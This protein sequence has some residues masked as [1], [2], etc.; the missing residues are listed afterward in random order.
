MIASFT[1]IIDF[2]TLMGKTS[3]LALHTPDVKT[4]KKMMPGLFQTFRK[5][6]YLGASVRITPQAGALPLDPLGVSANPSDAQ[7]DPRDVF[8]PILFR[9]CHGEDLGGIMNNW[10]YANANNDFSGIGFDFNQIG[11][12]GSSGLISADDILTPYYY[13]CLVDKHWKKVDPNRGFSKGNFRPLVYQ[14]AS[15]R[16]LNPVSMDS[17]EVFG[18][19]QDYGTSMGESGV[20]SVTG[21]PEASISNDD[22][23]VKYRNNI[24]FLTPRLTT[25]GWM[26]TRQSL[27]SITTPA[28]QSV[29][30]GIK[31]SEGFP[32]DPNPQDNISL[33]G[34]SYLEG[35]AD[36]FNPVALP[37]LFMGVWILP[38][39]QSTPGQRYFR[40]SVVHRFAFKDLRGISEVGDY[41]FSETDDGIGNL[42]PYNN[43]TGLDAVT[44]SD[45]DGPVMVNLY[46]DPARVS[47]MNSSQ[48]TAFA[49]AYVGADD[50]VLILTESEFTQNY[51]YTGTGSYSACNYKSVNTGS[52]AAEKPVVTFGL[53]KA[54]GSVSDILNSYCILTGDSTVTSVLLSTDAP[55]FTVK[56]GNIGYGSLRPLAGVGKILSWSKRSDG[57]YDVVVSVTDGGSNTFNITVIG[58][59]AN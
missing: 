34:L 13:R 46:Y 44:P 15:T 43:I 25:L 57:N 19:N 14:L 6:K 58:V 5:Y 37:K 48:A 8:N 29:I 39:A 53:N 55:T 33:V 38:P 10:V 31:A 18:I 26:D 21:V 49:N 50:D 1:E 4:A 9:G 22:Y 45:P 32:A 47:K 20:L 52:A 23:P 36:S 54:L 40:A 7:M 56:S 30:D 17:N 27:G 41:S 16:P 2:N 51:V 28:Y 11:A 24:Q 42:T 3:V 35:M 59:D 12:S